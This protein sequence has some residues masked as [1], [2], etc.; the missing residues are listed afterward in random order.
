MNKGN[1]TSESLGARRAE[2]SN[3]IDKV[4]DKV[5]QAVDPVKISASELEQRHDSLRRKLESAAHDHNAWDMLR[6]EIA[7]DVTSLEQ[8]FERWIGHLDA[9]A[10]RSR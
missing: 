8:D 5:V 3:Q 9:S 6:Y 2:L 1:E 4:R 7:L 10:N